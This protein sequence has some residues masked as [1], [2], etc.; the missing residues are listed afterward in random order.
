[1]TAS[2]SSRTPIVVL[3]TNT[4]LDWLL[5]QNAGMSALA[6]AVQAGQVRWVTCARMRDE[7]QRTLAYANL[8]AWSPDSER[9]LACFDRSAS[10]CPTPPAT[11]SPWQCSDADDQVFVDL[12]LAEGA[13]WLVTH[14]RAV[15]RLSKRARAHGLLIGKPA[16][17]H[18]D[19]PDS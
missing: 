8:A 7:F 18:L 3:D 14:D 11:A 19:A 6:G 12:A 1:M 4:V 9:L 17:W 2:L 13:R 16:A 10:V 5:F 15:L